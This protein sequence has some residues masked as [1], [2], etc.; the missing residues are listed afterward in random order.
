MKQRT[1]QRALHTRLIGA[2]A[3]GALVLPVALSLVAHDAGGPTVSRPSV[4]TS[5][6]SGTITIT[7]ASARWSTTPRTI[8]TAGS[9]WSTTPRTITPASS[10]PVK[11]SGTI[12]I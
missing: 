9:R 4:S 12:S 7:T 10:Q 3:A 2:A 11:W 1:V 6:A 8:T 5:V